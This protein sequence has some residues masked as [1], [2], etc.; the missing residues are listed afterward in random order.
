MQTIRLA[1]ASQFLL[2]IVAVYEMWSQV[3]GQSHLDVMPWT[4]KLLLGGGAA[5]AVVKA[6]HAAVTQERAW[7]G[8]TLKWV[9]IL[10]VLLVCCGLASYYSHLY[11]EDNGDDQ[12]DDNSGVGWVMPGG[13]GP[14]VRELSG[15]ASG[16]PGGRLR[17]CRIS[18]NTCGS[19]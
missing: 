6:T 11:L 5:L 8:R 12:S 14:Q 4:I 15:D 2:A 9:G 3:G 13:P 7:N 17:I 10:I 19:C 1:Y 16:S 18:R